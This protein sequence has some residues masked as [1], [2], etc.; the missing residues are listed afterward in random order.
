MPLLTKLNDGRCK[1]I[2]FPVILQVGSTGAESFET[3]G[4]HRRV[5]DK[6]TLGFT[7][8]LSSILF[9]CMRPNILFS[10]KFQVH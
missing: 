5:C 7:P 10:K 8:A 4:N 9:L 6:S 2:C 3:L 1:I